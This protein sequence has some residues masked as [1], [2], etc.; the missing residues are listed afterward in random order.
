V[1]PYADIK[2]DLV[3]V[4]NIRNFDYR[5]E[6]DFTPAYHARRRPEAPGPR[7]SHRRLLDRPGHRPPVRQPR[8]FPAT[9]PVISRGH[10]PPRPGYALFEARC[11]RAHTRRL[12]FQK[13]NVNVRRSLR[14]AFCW[15]IATT[16]SWRACAGCS[17]LR[18]ERWFMVADE[19]SLLEEPAGSGPTWRSWISL[20]RGTAACAG[21]ERSGS[22]VP[23]S[24]SSC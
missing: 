9:N 11:H 15:Q 20:W 14:V 16:V 1:L 23:T 2:G 7:R 17:R 24:R 21:C 5:T 3:T 19:A 22:V 13:G 6:T 10:N 18:S 4:H 8:N 12:R